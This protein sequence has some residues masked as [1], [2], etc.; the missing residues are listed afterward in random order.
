M[1]ASLPVNKVENAAIA[2]VPAM[3]GITNYFEPVNP[4]LCYAV[5]VRRTA[6]VVAYGEGAR[7]KVGKIAKAAGWGGILPKADGSTPTLLGDNSSMSAEMLIMI[8]ANAT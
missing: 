8:R 7:E 5:W 1:L 2:Q 3:T 6:E 4:L